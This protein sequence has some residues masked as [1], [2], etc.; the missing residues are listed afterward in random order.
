MAKLDLVFT[1]KIKEPALGGSLVKKTLARALSILGIAEQAVGLSVN[2]V[3]KAEMRA[4]NK[5]FRKIDKPTDV[6]SF[7]LASPKPGAG[8]LVFKKGD[9]INTNTARELGDIFLC[10]PLAAKTAVGFGLNQ[11]QMLTRLLVHGLLH[12]LGYD[13]Q[14]KGAAAVMEKLEKKIISGV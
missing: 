2:V 1:N 7:P 12:L 10:P 5:R 11:K 4:L 13:H 8:G 6:L 3:T 9:I 14:N